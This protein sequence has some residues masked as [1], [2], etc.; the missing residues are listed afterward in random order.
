MRNLLGA[1]ALALIFMAVAAKAET[2]NLLVEGGGEMLQKAVAEKFTRE[3]GIEVKFTVVPYQGVFD[4]FSAEIASGSSAFDVVTID[5]VWNAKFANH[6]EDLSPLFTDAVRKDLPPALLAD[7][8][9]G[10]KMIGMPAWANAEI[11]FYRKDLFDK[12]E[13]KEAF[14][15]KYGYPLAPP[16]TWQQWRD[17]AKFFTRDTDGDGKV[18]FWGTDTIGTFSEEWM[19]HVLQAGSPGVIL[20][21]DG[22]VIIDNEAHKKALEFYIAPHCADHSVPENVNEIGWGEAQNLFYQGKTAMM[23]FWAHAYKMTPEDSKV[24]G[25]VGVAPMLAGDAGIAAIPGP[26]YNVIPSASQHKD[27]AKKFIAFAIA[28]NGLGIEAKLGLAAT[29]SAYNSYVGKSGYE[30]FKPLLETLS[31]PAT[32]GRP[33]NE[34]YQEIIDEAVLPAVQQALTCKADVGGVLTEAKETI[35]DILN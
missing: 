3:T 23:K 29:N 6:V 28:N 21:K 31:A 30:H 16:K 10:D 34:K 22:N 8:K 18:D 7:A 2:I 35:E 12:P 26:W 20:D 33:I 13:E 27:A 17:M 25:K 9:A 5:V 24:S 1:S 19:A 11:V 14:Q 15:A 4:K 32:Q